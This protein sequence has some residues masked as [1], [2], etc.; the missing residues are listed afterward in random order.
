L[1]HLQLGVVRRAILLRGI[2]ALENPEAADLSGTSVLTLDGSDDPF[3][4]NASTLA[5][6][7][8]VRGAHVESRELSAG[9]E[10]AAADVTEAA[11]WI[12]RNLL[13]T[14]PA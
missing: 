4:C 8:R 3:A 11:E 13:G 1:I 10:L 7:L 5:E 6:D 14:P 12:R 2:Q 9:H